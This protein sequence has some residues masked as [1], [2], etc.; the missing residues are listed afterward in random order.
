MAASEIAESCPDPKIRRSFLALA[1]HWLWAA[2]RKP[3]G[4]CGK[5]QTS[6]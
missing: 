6:A 2:E 4:M 1:A 5:A 3:R